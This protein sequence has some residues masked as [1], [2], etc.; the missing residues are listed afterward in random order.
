MNVENYRTM[1]TRCRLCAECSPDMVPVL[2]EI[3]LS[4][5]IMQLFQVKIGPDD[6]LPTVVCRCCCTT[7]YS[8]WEF[9]QR[10]QKAQELLAVEESTQET[11]DPLCV[12]A[13]QQY[14]KNEP[15]NTE[16]YT[17][18]E[19]NNTVVECIL[20]DTANTV[21]AEQSKR[22]IKPDRIKV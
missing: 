18:T 3:E 10:V 5:K 7:V 12:A 22:K 8:T 4:E 19:T 14:C 2:E 20:Y 21:A 11:L 16:W 9:N 6:R 15:L 1:E 13:T 17:K